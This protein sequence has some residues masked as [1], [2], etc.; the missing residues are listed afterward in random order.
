MQPAF[1]LWAVNRRHV[2]MGAVGIA[3]YALAMGVLAGTLMER[4]RFDQKRAVVLREY[5]EKTA[6][7]RSRLMELEGTASL[8]TPALHE[9]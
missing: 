6:R 4:V 5:E 7:V 1:E 8:L 9:R 3:A 2:W